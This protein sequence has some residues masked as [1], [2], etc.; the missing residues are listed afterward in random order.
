MPATLW[1]RSARGRRICLSRSASSCRSP[2]SAATTATSARAA[3]PGSSRPILDA[4][5]G[6]CLAPMEQGIR[7]TTGAEFAPRDAAPTPVQFVGC[8]R[9][10]ANCSRSASRSRRSHGGRASVLCRSRPVIGARPGTAR[11]VARL[12]PRP[13]GPDA[14]S[15]DRPA[16]S[17][18]DDGATP[19]CDPG[20]TGRSGSCIDGGPLAAAAREVR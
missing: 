4:E 8:C 20:R 19:F 18:D 11:A 15:G 10:R 17:R 14:G 16:G 7:L 2:S 12:R 6:Y 1:S 13:L 5:N 9:R 3:T